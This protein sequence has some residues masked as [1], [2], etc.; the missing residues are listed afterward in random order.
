MVLGA[1]TRRERG[2]GEGGCHPGRGGLRAGS[3]RSIPGIGVG[4]SEGGP[5]ARGNVAGW[6]FRREV[7][8]KQEARRAGQDQET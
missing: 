6:V 3:I 7:C 1:G 8:R 2:K 5:G 4:V